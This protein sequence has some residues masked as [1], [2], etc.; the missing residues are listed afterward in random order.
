MSTLPD[1]A[2]PTVDI[3]ANENKLPPT[4]NEIIDLAQSEITN[5]RIALEN[6]LQEAAAA[7]A[8]LVKTV[9]ELK[10]K[11]NEVPK[12]QYVEK[13]KYVEVPALVVTPTPSAPKVEPIPEPDLGTPASKMFPLFCLP[14]PFD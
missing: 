5:Y 13:I 1:S 10:E 14:N 11:I 12:I 9:A 8:E 4:V 3:G 2:R 6:A 7:K